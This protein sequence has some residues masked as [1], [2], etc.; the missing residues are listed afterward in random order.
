MS[1]LTRRRFLQYGA[2]AGVTLTVPWVLAR[3]ASADMGGKLA[4]YV[5][6]VPVPGAGI[7]VATPSGT[8][9]YAFTHTEIF[10]QLHPELPPVNAA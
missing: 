2:G 3:S 10:R 6:P 4:K 5:Q 8:D 1:G 9:E 7:V